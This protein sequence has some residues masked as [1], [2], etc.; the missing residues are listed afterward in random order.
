[1]NNK[2]ETEEKSMKNIMVIFM[3]RLFTSSNP[4]VQEPKKYRCPKVG[5]RQLE[6]VIG[7]QTNEAPIKYVLQKLGEAHHLETIYY[8]HTKEVSEK[9][10]DGETTEEYLKR[11]IGEYCREKK[12]KEPE[13]VPVEFSQK[14]KQEDLSSNNEQRNIEQQALESTIEMVNTI[15][16]TKGIKNT[17]AYVD[18][19]G[20]FRNTVMILMAVMRLLQFCG[21]QMKQVLYSDIISSPEYPE[22][23]DMTST[24][25]IMY[26]IISGANEFENF[27][28]VDT[29]ER[30]LQ[31][32]QTTDSLRNLI[33]SMKTFSESLQLCKAE[34]F[35][36][37]LKQLRQAIEKFKNETKNMKN[38]KVFDILMMHIEQEYYEI[39]KEDASIPT[40][41]K[42]CANKGFIQQAL[43]LYIEL[44]PSYLVKEKIIQFV[45]KGKKQEEIEKGLESKKYKKWETELMWILKREYDKRRKKGIKYR[46]FLE[47][48]KKKEEIIIKE[49]QLKP[50]SKIIQNYSIV[51]VKRNFACHANAE[52]KLDSVK[53]EKE[54]II[55]AIDDILKLTKDAELETKW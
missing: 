35:Q 37:G 47:E 50:L 28:R 34:G 2:N 7:K 12:Y 49:K 36:E 44:I 48:L 29:L 23:V 17:N 1:M 45:D 51:N 6:D 43:T 42:W 21:I 22:I 46:T 52:G 19:T 15:K 4:K 3:S 10:D 13:F 24:Y 25:N 30:C 27:G 26:D 20:G 54:A 32:E 18:I 55:N 38:E 14:G 33:D 11:V 8:F 41:I 39:I 16:N 53:N 9:N 31:N 40:I 5:D